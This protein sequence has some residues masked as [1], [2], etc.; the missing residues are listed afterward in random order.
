MTAFSF[1]TVEHFQLSSSIFF[2]GFIFSSTVVA[3]NT[4]KFVH[5]NKFTEW[6]ALPMPRIV[7]FISFVCAIIMFY[8]ALHL[9][10]KVLVVAL[11]FGLITISYALPIFQNRTNLRQV[12]GIKI[13]IIAFVWAGVTVGLP[14]LQNGVH[15]LQ[16]VI[17]AE[18]IQRF[19]FV[20]V[21]TLPFDIRDLNEDD[22][23]LGTIPQL[24]G[25]KKTKWIGVAFL[26]VVIV[27][28]LVL[29]QNRESNT[30]I[31]FMIMIL[32]AVFLWK[33]MKVQSRYFA[34]FWVESTPILWALAIVFDS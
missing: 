13:L 33:S 4:T 12:F 16:P 20:I 9:E 31:F 28:E 34:S 5:L 14:I 27:F 22:R 7:K 2:Y 18:F 3:Y 32:T 17:I 19:L 26:F 11:I 29:H 1:I 15:L 30:I 21:L 24:F 23:A 6:L 8:T 25:V 10:A